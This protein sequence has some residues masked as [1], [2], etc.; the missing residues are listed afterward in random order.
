[1]TWTSGAKPFPKCVRG[2]SAHSGAQA[3]RKP[4]LLDHGAE[5]QLAAVRADLSP[6]AK[7]ERELPGF[8]RVILRQAILTPKTAFC[9]PRSVRFEALNSRCHFSLRQQVIWRSFSPISILFNPNSEVGMGS[10]GDPPVPSGHWPDGTRPTLE[11]ERDVRKSSC[12]FSRSERR[13]AARHRPVACATQ[14]S[15]QRHFGVR[16][17]GELK[18]EAFESRGFKRF[19][20]WN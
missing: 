10:T 13:V 2:S 20:E 9:S 11:L 6:V 19:A 16:V 8:E 12:A 18:N 14:Q 17:H 1:M 5:G 3:R 15:G 4:E 7:F